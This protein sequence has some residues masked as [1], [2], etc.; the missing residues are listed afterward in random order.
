MM[1]DHKNHQWEEI[2][3]RDGRVFTDLLPA[4]HEA[5]ETFSDHHC[6]SILDLGCGTGR[7]VVGFCGAGFEVSGFDIS[8]TGL[9]LTQAWLDEAALEATLVCGDTRHN[10]PFADNSFQGLFSTQ[11]IHH[12][13]L[14]EVRHT[15]KEIWRILKPAGLAFISVAARTHKDKS[16]KEIEPGTFIPQEGDEKGLPHHIFSP[17]EL[18]EEFSRFEILDLEHRA[19]GRVM[20]IWVKKQ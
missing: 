12:A 5:V 10:L 18:R 15:I 9:G 14:E 6:E 8:L 16:Y 4:F 2:Y 7:H 1:T 19:D 13:L 11:V 17:E 20:I 3:R